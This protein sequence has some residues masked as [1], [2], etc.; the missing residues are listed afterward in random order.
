MKPN[1]PTIISPNG[2][3]TFTSLVTIAWSVP[4]TLAPDGREVM[5]D[6]YFTDNF[7]VNT[8]PEWIQLATLPAS[9]N[10]YAWTPR[11][12]T[13]SA[14]CRIAIRS[15]NS[16]GERSEYVV[17]ESDFSVFR[18]QLT[19]PSVV[20]PSPGGTYDKSVNIQ[21]D[22]SGIVNTHSQRTYSASLGIPQTAIAQDIPI[23]SD[24]FFWNTIQLEA[25]GDYVL[26]AFLEDD[27]GNSSTHVFVPFAIIH[28][29]YFILDTLPPDAAI[30]INNNAVF[31]NKQT[32]S[33]QI[34]S[35]DAATAVH[36]MQLLEPNG[37]SGQPDAPSGSLS[38]GLSSGDGVKAIELLLQD[39]GGNRNNKTL[40]RLFGVLIGIVGT[41]VVDIAFDG[42]GDVLWAVTSGATN[43]LYQ[44]TAFSSQKTTFTNTP[45]AVGIFEGTPFVGTVNDNNQGTLLKFTSFPETVNVFTTADSVINTIN[46]YGELLYVGME[47]GSIYSF[48]GIAVTLVDTLSKPIKALVTD[49]SLLY[50]V[51]KNELNVYVFNGSSFVSTGG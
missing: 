6:V 50:A 10:Q 48:N 39:F 31:T 47:N 45:T 11:G 51:L 7:D 14:K 42:V 22:D 18:K 15:V 28:E 34:A 17:S 30:I 24:P 5:F 41:E 25:A 20:S 36:S 43:V 26:E 3:N 1:A 16:R 29:G 44:V 35:Y 4:S 19:A 2:G 37:T 46:A 38:Y 40:Q 8:E 27:E 12:G 33:V 21:V 23:G 9:V 32:V 13:N 49:G